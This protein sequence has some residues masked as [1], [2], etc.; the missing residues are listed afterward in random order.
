MDSIDQNIVK[1]GE[2]MDVTTK[3]SPLVLT[4]LVD[5]LLETIMYK[6]DFVDLM[7]MYSVTHLFRK[8]SNGMFNNNPDLSVVVFEGFNQPDSC[9]AGRIDGVV[10][11]LRVIGY[12]NI[13]RYVKLFHM[14]IRDLTIDF[15]GV[16]KVTQ[17]I[18]S[19]FIFKHCHK[20]LTRL[21]IKNLTTGLNFKPV[22]FTGIKYLK[23]DSCFLGGSMTRLKILFPNINEISLVGTTHAKY[24]EI[25]NLIV[26]YPYLE[27]MKITPDLLTIT[28]YELLC[29]HNFKAF[30]AYRH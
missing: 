27:Y 23:L 29:R 5:E 12:D 17:R 3:S 9:I 22:K 26:H 1:S 2:A 30:S 24:F 4:D 15:R 13:V 10:K 21:T 8:I 25:L 16:D 28:Q 20:F 18:L 19:L 7:R 14:Y 6:M 11:Q